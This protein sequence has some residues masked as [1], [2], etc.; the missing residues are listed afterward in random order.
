[1]RG[2]DYYQKTAF[3]FTHGRWAR[4]MRFSAAE[5]TTGYPKRSAARQLRGLA[6]PSEKIGWCFP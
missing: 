2:L 6:L 1:V 4:R 3:E 5:D